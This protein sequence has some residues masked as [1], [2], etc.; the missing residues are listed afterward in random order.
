LV[1]QSNLVQQYHI[2]ICKILHK[3][4]SRTK[5]SEQTSPRM[6]LQ[7]QEPWNC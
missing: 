4:M 5:N 3:E 6:I 1:P 2:F 7:R